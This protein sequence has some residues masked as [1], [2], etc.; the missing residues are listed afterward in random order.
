MPTMLSKALS[1]MTDIFSQTS[2]N[3]G[4]LL[5]KNNAVLRCRLSEGL[6]K[7]IVKGETGNLYDVYAD[8][9]TW[10]LKASTC[11]CR[12]HFNCEHVAACFYALSPENQ[13][14][15]KEPASIE[16]KAPTNLI[17]EIDIDDLDWHSEI[18]ESDNH[19]FSYQLGI[20]IDGKK[21]DILPFVLHLLS[22][23]DSSNLKA[24][25][26]DAIIELP[27][28]AEN[29]LRVSMGRLRPLLQFLQQ[30]RHKGEIKLKNYQMVL[31]KEM[32][33]AFVASRLRWHNGI[34]LQAQLQ[35]ILT[36]QSI[37]AKAEPRGLL[38]S[39][40]DYQQQGLGWLQT[41][42]RTSLGGILA[43]DMGLGK[44]V[45]T[46]A[47][48]QVEK[49]EGRLAKASLILAP[50][51]L[52]WNWFEEA[53]KYTPELRVLV[54][55]GQS[56]HV[57]HFDDYDVIISTY[58]LIQRDKEQ[59]IKHSFYYFILDEAQFIKNARAKTTQ[60]IQQVKA[61]QRLC[62]SGTPIENHLGELWSLFHF[63][64][65]GFLGDAP[66]FKT[67]FK[68]PIEKYNDIEKRAL[69]IQRIKPFILRRT[70]DQVAKELPKK[71]ETTTLIE[72]SG[73][74]R[75][76]YET[77]RVSMEKKVRDAIYAQG[78]AKSHIVFLDALLKLRQ[79]CCDPR[80]LKLPESKMAVGSSAKLTALMDLISS[81]MAE[82]RHVLIFSQFTTM[83]EF[84]EEKLKEHQYPYL[85]LTGQTQK[86]REMIARFQKG[87]VPIF[88]ISL[89]AGG[90]GLNLTR[91][92]TVIHYDPWWNPKV[93]D[94]ATDRTH[95]IGQEQPVFV[96]KLIAAGTVEEAI[97]AL[98]D[99]KR[100]LV[101]GILTD[102]LQGLSG[103]KPE[104]LH[105]F[106]D[107]DPLNFKT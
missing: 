61:E 26:D 77:I 13:Q 93:A 86:R 30:F 73:V 47:H 94:Q 53:K 2:L 74:Q 19:F 87:E 88:L 50:T 14:K 6:L 23:W 100:Q 82:K 97:I 57:N 105:A 92:D 106:F 95:R 91:A 69:L 12:L 20:E 16:R 43:D 31:I 65:P 54:F 75:D 102:E 1:K 45:Q 27:M 24:W 15:T 80:L 39:L 51:S 28:N 99:K 67:F 7:G 18:Q 62:L 68:I 9:K 36:M 76:L 85:K 96:Y 34:K 59:F 60:V 37:E 52:V 5:Y 79:V 46:L 72:L 84:I 17:R 81:L 21:V 29:I 42:R 66:Y 10:P 83:L 41:L 38:T 101:E 107:I 90:T 70:K 64:M 63:L 89:K 55:H 32:E 33:A 8:M 71:T 44:T 98:Q 35:Q 11:S 48:L 103:L 104:D 22:R 58:A 40:R 4:I 56:R 25:S 78:L 49:E 3:R